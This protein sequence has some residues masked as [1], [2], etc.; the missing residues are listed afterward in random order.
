MHV[1]SKDLDD[2]ELRWCIPDR[3]LIGEDSMLHERRSV[4]QSSK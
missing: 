1:S 2:P 4:L 3:P